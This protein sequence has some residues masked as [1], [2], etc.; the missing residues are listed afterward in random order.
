MSKNIPDYAPFS[1]W[2]FDEDMNLINLATGQALTVDS[3]SGRLRLKP[4]AYF[5]KEPSQKWI[6]DYNSKTQLNNIKL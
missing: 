1:F 4:K 2:K 5:D 3:Y 6:L